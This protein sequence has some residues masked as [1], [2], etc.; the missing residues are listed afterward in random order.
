MNTAAVR[1]FR[2]KLVNEPVLGP[3][4]KTTD[5]AVAEVLSKAGFDFVIIDLEHGPNTVENVHNLIRAVELGGALA[6]VRTAAGAEWEIGAALDA[7]AAGVQVPHVD[8]PASAREAVRRARFAPMGERGVCRYVRGADFSFQDKRDYLAEAN[9]SLVVVQVEGRLGLDNL[10][11]IVAVPGID[12][13]FIGPYDLSQSL[14]VPGEVNH[15]LVVDAVSR[16]SD[17]GARQGVTVGTFVDTVDEARTWAER[18]VR[19]ISC[20][21]DVGI[22]AQA[23]AQ[24]IHSFGAGRVF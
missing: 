12:V 18:G 1:R 9:E 23:S 20:S 19:Y 7:G 13:A 10:E 22:M 21:V 8:D 24:M 3:F 4:S 14:G 2:A 17:V 16:A 15:P 5:P 6:I 11:E